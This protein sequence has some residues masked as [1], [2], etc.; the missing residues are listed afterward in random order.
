[1]KTE[2]GADVADIPGAGAEGGLGAGLMAFLGAETYSGID[3]V[4][5]VLNLDQYLEEA[6]VVI[7]GEGS[8]DSSTVYNK[9]PVGVAKRA[10]QF[11]VP[12]IVVSGFLGAGYEAV[13]D[14]GI[15]GIVS[16]QDRPM[17]MKVSLNESRRLLTESISRAMKLVRIGGSV[18]I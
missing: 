13:Y 17:S 10:K 2:I 9:A 8:V 14:H 11:G 16:I 15:D 3:L 18:N 6:D 4:C 1:M 7:T 12:V 5:D